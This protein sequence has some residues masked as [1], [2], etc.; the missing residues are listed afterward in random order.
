M[1]WL[2]LTL[3]APLPA[4]AQPPIAANEVDRSKPVPPRSETIE[5]FQRRQNRVHSFR[6]TWTEQQTHPTGWIPN[7]RFAE[8]ERLR[9]PTLYRDRTYTVSKTLQ[10]DGDRMRYSFEIDRPEEP[11]GVRVKSSS[12]ATGGLGLRR[13][14]AYISAFDGQRG[15]T[16]LT[17]ITGDNPD[18]V[19][20]VTSSMDAQNLDLRPIMLALRPLHPAMGHLL[21]DRAVPNGARSFYREKSIF[22]LE[23]RHDPSG[24]KTI[25]WVE[26][27]RD[28]LVTRYAMYFEQKRIVDIE[29][30]H[31]ED[32]RWGWIPSAWRV[33]EMLEDGSSRL[34]SEARVTGYGINL[35]TG[36]EPFR[37]P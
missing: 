11:D 8:R 14:Y 34:V 28:F 36:D 27:E 21:I 23:E 22:L 32:A 3:L 5:A 17:T 26:P 12:G 37:D 4:P 13:H 30:D 9:I 20:S 18:A 16:R 15:W 35:P 2:C 24:W 29:I 6:F 7:P 31:L 10:V 33:T 25:L 1:P 19:Q